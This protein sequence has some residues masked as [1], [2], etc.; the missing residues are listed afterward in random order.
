MQE[1]TDITKASVSFENYPIILCPLVMSPVS[2]GFPSPADDYIESSIDLNRELIRHPSATFLVRARGDSM[3]DSG[4]RPN[5]TLIVDRML[6]TKPGDI[7]VA[8][9]G[10]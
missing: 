10:D 6:E 9:I 2:A 3:I 4:I 8:R 7:V 5:S 1:I